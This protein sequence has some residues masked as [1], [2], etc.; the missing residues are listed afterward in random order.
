M[1]FLLFSLSL[2]LSFSLLVWVGLILFELA[3]DY[4]GSNNL[5]LYQN[6]ILALLRID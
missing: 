5:S 4:F 1:K 6:T 3:L 2:S